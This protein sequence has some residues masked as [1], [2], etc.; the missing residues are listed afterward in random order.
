LELPSQGL[1]LRKISKRVGLSPQGVRYLLAQRPTITQVLNCSGCGRVV[2][3][4][5][6]THSD[7]PA[8]CPACVSARRDAVRG[9]RLRALR[10]AA[11]LAQQRLAD[12]LGVSQRRVNSWEPGRGVTSGNNLHRLAAALGVNLANLTGDHGTTP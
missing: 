5:A 3:T 2:A 7:G 12:L 10:L 1:G 4:D 9:E 6:V 11:G 8:L